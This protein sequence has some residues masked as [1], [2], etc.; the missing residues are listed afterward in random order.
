VSG[1]IGWFAR[2]HVAANIL[3]ALIVVAGLLTLP[4]IRQE[5]FP[6]I[7][8]P[9]ISVSVDYP[10]ASP[11]EVEEA[12]CARIEEALTGMQGMTRLNATAS[13]G[14]GSVTIELHAD[15]DVAQRMNDVRTRV[16]RIDTFPVD[17]E[18]PVVQQAE[19]RFPVLD[20]AVA[21]HVDERTL[22]RLGE[23][24]RDEIASLPGISHVD[25]IAARHDE[26]SIEIS[27]RALQR[28]GLTF[29][30]VVAA[31]QRSS[32]DMPG[33][34]VK[35]RGGEIR[36]RTLGQAYDGLDFE[37]IVVMSRA[38]GTRLTVGDVGRVVD[39]FE[40]SDQSSR[41]DGQP[42]VIVQIFRVGEQSALEISSTVRAYIADAQRGL[43]AGITMTL[44][45]DDARFLRQRLDSLQRNAWSGFVL[46][47]LVLA[48]F[49]RLRLAAW[50][51]MGIPVS[52][53]GA[54]AL[55]PAMDVSINLISLM[56]FIVVLGIVVDDAIVVGENTCTEQARMKDALEGAISGTRG[57]AIPVTF[58]VL[59]TVAAF[60]PM[61]FVD[62][63]M[64]RV[65]RVIPV[66]VIACL[67]LSLFESLFILPAHLAHGAGRTD[68]V[69]KR[70]IS[71]G[72]RSFQD[73]I[74]S[75]LER[76]IQ[77]RYRAV[78][79]WALEWRYLTAA[80]ALTSLIV[81]VGM[82]GGG[83]LR[84]VFQPDV[85]GDVMVAYL[86]MP[87]GTPAEVTANAIAQIERAAESVR[88]EIDDEQ[89]GDV[90]TS[91]FS[92]ILT[93]VGTQ[94]YRLKQASGP[95]AFE[96][97]Y[98]KAGNLGEVQIEVVSSE[99]RE[100]T[101]AE[102]TR[103]WRERTGQIP[104]A[105]ELTF[106]SSIMSAGAPMSIELRGSELETLR[107]AAAA[108]REE[109]A[110]HAG[111]I[112]ISDSFRGGK[113]ELELEILPGAEALGL[114]LADLGRQVRQAFF[115]HEVQRV[116]RG[117]EDVPVMVRYPEADRRSLGDLEQMR[118]RTAEGVAVPFSTV[119]QARLADG[120][121]SIRR[122][123]RKRAV[124]V[125]ANVDPALGNANEIN[126]ALR[127]EFLGRLAK[128][129]PD[130][131]ISL[132]GE[133]REQTHFLDS[134][135]RG[136]LV[137]LLA[138]YALLAIPLR[139]YGQPLIIMSAIPFGLVGAVWGHVLLGHDFS[140]FS[141]IGVVALSGV[142]VNDSLV[143]VDSVNQRRS[144]GEDLATAIRSAGV[145]RFR[146]ILL[147]SLT[148]F[149]GL[150][151]M[152]A[153]TSVQSQMLI[154]MAISLAF[155]VVFATAITLL[156]VPAIYLILDDFMRILRGPGKLTPG[157]L[158]DRP[159]EPWPVAGDTRTTIA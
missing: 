111:V 7:A 86:S 49:L 117:R 80:L 96:R 23:R 35:T 36:V 17:S 136:W 77:I 126:A 38:D 70:A 52:F 130:V 139:S 72:W 50:V 58:G 76:F 66:V 16:D 27:E 89:A 122:V 108:I 91:V 125:T 47:F 93:S 32:I 64:G 113:Q 75:G 57:V 2:N 94:P 120:L 145:S 127:G 79:E 12:I 40:E 129:F 53:L 143:L 141:L 43:P 104:G 159:T 69:P 67:M 123:D 95:A 137:A 155:G 158:D 101:V 51:T 92:H 87:A 5:V 33:G 88:A 132:S 144:E 148:T 78:L 84:F 116:Q 26:I 119:A 31:V 121:S 30:D 6:S 149:A 1:L 98:Q 115:G 45:Q 133:Q 102:M 62:G 24:T 19:L 152:M 112:D 74:A 150:T 68:D 151:P 99:Q 135:K 21:G 128:A 60:A 56:G 142:V 140:M 73:S 13:E 15:E 138:I 14:R 154:P 85:E 63:P 41:F 22:K 110:L 131:D 25:L 3:M 106:S 147:T 157:D 8:L 83:W 4:L 44:A 37:R 10:G 65:A 48:L 156:L 134:L 146:A 29:D 103:R 61:L 54:L 20:V 39:G 59:T 97:A 46:V 55:L 109:L 90:D 9:V 124:T 42:A 105:E 107:A 153:E 18:A 114:T 34:T 11:E 81:T 28:H 71:R 82:L 100:S 118:I